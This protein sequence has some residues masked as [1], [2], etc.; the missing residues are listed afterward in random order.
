MSGQFGLATFGE[1]PIPGNVA[2]EDRL[3]NV[4]QLSPL[5]GGSI[6]R[7]RVDRVRSIH[8][9]SASHMNVISDRSHN[10]LEQAMNR[11]LEINSRD[12]LLASLRQQRRPDSEDAQGTE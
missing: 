10:I 11:R 6:E 2:L 3:A 12:A 5:K 4:R 8:S 9:W 1:R 7:D